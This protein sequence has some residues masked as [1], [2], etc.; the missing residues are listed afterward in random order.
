VPIAPT[1]VG[2]ITAARDVANPDTTIL[3][4][5][6]QP[7]VSIQQHVTLLLT[8][9][10]EES[11]VVVGNPAVDVSLKQISD[12]QLT[13]APATTTPPPPTTT[14]LKFELNKET[15]TRLGIPASPGIDKRI[16]AGQYLIRPRLRVDGVD[17]PIINYLVIPPV[18][19]GEQNLD[20]PL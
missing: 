10:K 17:S 8:I 12:R 18:F 7:P 1:L 14:T 15:L 19:I 20:I 5:Q 3:T 11:P 4:V 9:I 16:K 13:P 6:C 2:N